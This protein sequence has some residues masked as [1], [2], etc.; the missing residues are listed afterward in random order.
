MADEKSAPAAGKPPKAD[1]EAQGGAAVQDGKPV[2]GK[3]EGAG[4][5]DK[6]PEVEQQPT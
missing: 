5:V 3:P 2:D 1:G 4:P 6:K